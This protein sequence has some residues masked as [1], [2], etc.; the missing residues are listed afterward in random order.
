MDLIR[1]GETLSFGQYNGGSMELKTFMESIHELKIYSAFLKN[2]KKI[3][4]DKN[5]NRKASFELSKDS[6]MWHNKSGKLLLS[7]QGYGYEEY[8]NYEDDNEMHNIVNCIGIFGILDGKVTLFEINDV[9]GM[10][11]YRGELQ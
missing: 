6:E 7:L 4:L 3:T 11:Y 9:V 1:V 10:P 8:Q 5:T 2:D